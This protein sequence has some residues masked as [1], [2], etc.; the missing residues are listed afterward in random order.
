MSLKRDIAALDRASRELAQRQQARMRSN[1]HAVDRSVISSRPRRPPTYYVLRDCQDAVLDRLR[2]SWGDMFD[3]AWEKSRRV[4]N[5]EFRVF[6][7][8]VDK[9]P[10]L[11]MVCLDGRCIAEPAYN[12]REWVAYER[13]PRSAAGS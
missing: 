13:A 11:L 12:H 3:R 2:G 10:L 8:R 7:E 6:A 9:P 4:R 1:P 5:C